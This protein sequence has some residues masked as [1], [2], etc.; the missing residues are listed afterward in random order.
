MGIKHSGKSYHGKLFA[1]KRNMPFFDMDELVEELYLSKY[2]QALKCRLIFNKHG[3][4][5]FRKIEKETLRYFFSTCSDENFVLALGGGLVANEEDFLKNCSGKAILIYLKLPG[6]VL[7]KRIIENGIPPFLNAKNP[8]DDFS[9]LFA[10]RSSQLD[11]YATVIIELRDADKE[12]NGA[13]IA[14]RLKEYE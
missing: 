3:E 10:M 1:K 13:R 4:K 2:G 12:T 5:F 11:K 9:G 7:Y 6:E 8:W 14:E